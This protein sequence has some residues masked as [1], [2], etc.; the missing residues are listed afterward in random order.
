MKET[1]WISVHRSIFNHWVWQDKPFSKGQAWIDLILQANHS[2]GKMLIGKTLLEVKRGSFVTS[3]VK[4]SK[5]WGWSRCKVR[6]F[7]KLLESDS[8]LNKQ[9]DSKKTVIKVLNYDLYQNVQNEKSQQTIQPIDSK[10]TAESQQK[11]TNN[12]VNN[13]NNISLSQPAGSDDDKKPKGKPKKRI[14]E[15]NSAPYK[16]ACALKNF[17]M[18][19]NPKH[20]PITES[21]LQSWANEARLMMEADHRTKGDIWNVMKFS[22]TDDFWKINI[23]SMGKLRKQFDRLILKVNDVASDKESCGES[24]DYNEKLYDR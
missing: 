15:S 10:K 13:D 9:S 14:Y 8:M 17:I 7:L 2:T 12:N 18:E 22:Q 5:R 24:V 3:E 23:L 16:I 6:D 1:G 21:N 11:D 4:L 20:T 19:N